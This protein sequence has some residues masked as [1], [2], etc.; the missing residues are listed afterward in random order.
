MRSHAKTFFNRESIDLDAISYFF[1]VLGKKKIPAK[2]KRGHKR[3]KVRRKT[4]KHVNFQPIS[5]T[6]FHPHHS[7]GA[8][9]RKHSKS[10]EKKRVKL[11][12]LPHFN[13]WV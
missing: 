8:L 9:T 2:K 3:R 1:L 12:R 13:R 11:V 4:T 5:S 10:H 6:H 7:G